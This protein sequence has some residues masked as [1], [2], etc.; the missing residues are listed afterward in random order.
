[1]N[2]VEHLVCQHGVYTGVVV[3]VSCVEPVIE[4]LHNLSELCS[5]PRGLPG[6]MTVA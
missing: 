5:T 6:R 3:C 4:R 2:G 1:M